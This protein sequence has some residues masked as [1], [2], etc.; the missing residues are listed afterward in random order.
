[1]TSP[2]TR[3]IITYGTIMKKRILREEMSFDRFIN[4]LTAKYIAQ[5]YNLY[6]CVLATLRLGVEI[7]TPR[8]KVAMGKKFQFMTLPRNFGSMIVAWPGAISNSKEV[9]P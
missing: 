7:L 5:G 4:I 1:M 2:N 6:F 8:R 9:I 3:A